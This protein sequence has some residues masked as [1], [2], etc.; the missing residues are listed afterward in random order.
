MPSPHRTSYA[1]SGPGARRAMARLE[2]LP[3]SP[4]GARPALFLPPLLITLAAMLWGTDGLWRSQLIAAMPSS[5][6][7]VFWEHLLLVAATGWLPWRDRHQ[8]A[9]LDA[10]DWL[11]V[12]V[13]G[14]G[15]SALATVLFTQAFRL[16]NP[17]TVLLLQKAQPLVAIALATALLR[18]PLPGRFWP[19]VP[20]ALLGTYLISFG[21]AG[22]IASLAAAGDAPLGATMALGAATLWGTGTV[23]GRRLLAKLAFPTLTALRF[24]VALP[25]LAV[26]AAL[27]GWAIPGRTQV[28]PLVATALLAGLLGLLLYYRGLRETP[29]AVATLCELSFPITAIL[30]NVFLLGAPV[31]A[32]QVVGVALL[33][34]ALALMRHRPVPAEKVARPVPT[35]A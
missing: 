30:L 19:L 9:T 4:G 16:A 14:V 7:I 31:T 6:T 35:A 33:W 23:L 34:G 28:P 24:T 18:E 27:S 13:V 10:G 15:A 25:A 11:S 21:D 3:W 20:V 5:F 12:A 32:N 8:L 29:A 2:H 17:N 26:S 1:R 22:P